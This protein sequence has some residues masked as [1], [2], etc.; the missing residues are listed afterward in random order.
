LPI[1]ITTSAELAELRVDADVEA[2]AYFLIAE[3]LTNV[4]KHA[5]ASTAE[6]RLGGPAGMLTIEVRDDG[7]GFDTSTVPRRGLSGLADR[8]AAHGGAVVVVSRPGAG[9][10]VRATLPTRPVV[11][12]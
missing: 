8:I 5:H 12:P 4:V 10:T 3:A 2:A 6:V 7:D 11:A 9:T 1:N